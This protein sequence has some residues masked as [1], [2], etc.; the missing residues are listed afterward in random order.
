MGAE[1]TRE[2][3]LDIVG[4]VLYQQWMDEDI[5]EYPW[6]GAS[7]ET[8]REAKQYA[9]DIVDALDEATGR[10]VKGRPPLPANVR[11]VLENILTPGGMDQWWT[12]YLRM[13][14]LAQ[15]GFATE[16][17]RYFVATLKLGGAARFPKP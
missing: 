3:R 16:A 11:K 8:E 13:D 9:K 4:R 1:L 17:A 2:Q 5:D 14:P 12:G 6:E 15:E 7:N 10:I